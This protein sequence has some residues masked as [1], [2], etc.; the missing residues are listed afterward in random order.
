M[1]I[2][3]ALHEPGRG[4]WIGSDS[5]GIT[6]GVRLDVGP[7]WT[8]LQGGWWAGCAGNSRFQQL[9]RHRL[10]GAGFKTAFALA[11]AIRE[12]LRTDGFKDT[13]S[14]SLPYYDI[15]L[16]LANA[17]CVWVVSGSFDVDRIRPA[18]LWATGSGRDVALGAAHL[19][20]A[21][22]LPPEKTIRAALDAA[23]DLERGCGG[24]AFVHLIEA[25]PVAAGGA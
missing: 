4:T 9:L 8:D 22:G 14:D 7:K 18:T 16:M 21:Y 15:N 11:D 3:C 25:G 17:A 24:A 1:T 13:N 5:V 12:T 2:I 23:I 19:A 10:A 20:R 6:G